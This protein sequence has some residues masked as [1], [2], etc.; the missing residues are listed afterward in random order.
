[1]GLL[2]KTRPLPPFSSGVSSAAMTRV[3]GVEIGFA[4]DLDVVGEADLGRFL[5]RE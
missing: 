5:L 1:M 4:L 3:L 2:L